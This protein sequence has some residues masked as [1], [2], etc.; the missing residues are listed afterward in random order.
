MLSKA[1]LIVCGGTPEL[2]AAFKRTEVDHW[3]QVIKANDI[4]I[5]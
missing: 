3:P 2:F 4:K 1:N 5:E